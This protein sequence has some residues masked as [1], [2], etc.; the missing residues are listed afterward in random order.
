M[1]GKEQTKHK[2]QDVNRV[3]FDLLYGG[4]RVYLALCGVRLK[5]TDRV[6]EVKAPSIV[7]CN[8]GSFI[9]FIYAAALLRK[10]APHFVVARLYFYHRGLGWLLQKVGAFPKSMFALDMENARN[11]LTVLKRGQVLTMMPEARL[12]TA[13]RFEDIQDST[14]AFV[15][16][17]GV[18]VYTVKICGDYL[19]D[20]KWGKGFRRGALVEAELD[21]LYTAQ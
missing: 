9:D 1:A 6:G 8:H 7:L 13:G 2:V 16:K 11:C 10:H 18:D 19:A 5:T 20:P 15:K 21:L 3:L 17:A 12:S 14:C 4:V